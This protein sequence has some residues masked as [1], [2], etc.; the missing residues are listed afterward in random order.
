MARHDSRRT[1]HCAGADR[2]A[3]DIPQPAE[4]TSGLP[5]VGEG[6]SYPTKRTLTVEPP[7]GRL[8]FDQ[9]AFLSA[10]HSASLFTSPVISRMTSPRLSSAYRI[11]IVVVPNREAEILAAEA[12]S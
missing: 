5:R 12:V 10:S 2:P 8:I 7:Q 9:K 4:L 1:R 6:L 11:F 3:Q